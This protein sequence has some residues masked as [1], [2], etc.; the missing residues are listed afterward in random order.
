LKGH[1]IIFGC[2]WIKQ[3]NPIGLDLSDACKQLSITK[4]GHKK[5]LFDDFTAPPHQHLIFVAQLEKICRGHILG[6]VIQINLLTEQAPP[7]ATPVVPPKIPSMRRHPFSVSTTSSTCSSNLAA[8]HPPILL[9]LAAGNCDNHWRSS[10]DSLHCRTPPHQPL[11]V[12]SPAPHLHGETSHDSSCLVHS[13]LSTHAYAANPRAPRPLASCRHPCRH[14]SK[15]KVTAPGERHVAPGENRLTRPI[16]SAG[17]DQAQWPT[18][19]WQPAV[20][21]MPP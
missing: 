20:R 12:A 14:S 21:Y 7:T 6:Y 5:V 18:P 11:L 13:L 17:S 9:P 4:D 3:H 19:P 2:D 15:R 16:S 1:D 10:Y 8:P